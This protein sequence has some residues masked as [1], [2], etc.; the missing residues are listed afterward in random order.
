MKKGMSDPQSLVGSLFGRR[1]QWIYLW[2]RQ[3]PFCEKS[4]RFICH[5][6]V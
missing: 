3:P 1:L 6:P 2:R 5:P 4:N